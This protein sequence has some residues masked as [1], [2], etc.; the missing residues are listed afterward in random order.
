MPTARDVMT[1]SPIAIRQTAS[2]REAAEALKRL[3]VRHLPVVDED[4]ELI[5]MVSD[6]DLRDLPEVSPDVAALMGPRVTLESAVA[7]VMTGAP[8]AVAAD[9]DVA[10]IAD[11][12]V[13]HRI[14]AVPVVSPEGRLVGI[15]SY[16]DLLR[17]LARE[18]R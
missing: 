11:L 3:D 1:R 8:V 17:E 4:R 2:V 12:M 15:V 14:G 9:T 13:E 10:D 18:S 7:S 6:R 5:G 16:I